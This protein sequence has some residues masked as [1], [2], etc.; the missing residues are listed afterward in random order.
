MPSIEQTVEVM[1]DD[2]PILTTLLEEKPRQGHLHQPV[3]IPLGVEMNELPHGI[4]E[5][6]RHLVLDTQG[7]GRMIGDPAHRAGS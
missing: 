5:I 7:L 3:L 1:A 2:G 6:L 4:K